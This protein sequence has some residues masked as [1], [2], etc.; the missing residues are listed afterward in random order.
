MA[1]EKSEI[2][3]V[4]IKAI[5]DH[6]LYFT[7][8]VIA[9]VPC[10]RS[11]FY[12]YFP[13]SSDELDIIKAHLNENKIKMKVQLRQKLSKGEKAAEILALY[14]LICS[15]EER[16]ALQMVYSENKHEIVKPPIEW[17]DET[18]K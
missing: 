16:K 8:D 11:T 17:Q 9:Y 10:S 13:D 18:N 2:L 7:E 12:D 14:K 15:D 3:Q 5:E 4:A 6:S 1:Y